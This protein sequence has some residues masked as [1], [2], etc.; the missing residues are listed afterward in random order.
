MI[1]MTVSDFE[2]FRGSIFNRAFAEGYSKGQEVGY[3]E[4]NRTLQRR[5]H[6][7]DAAVHTSA[8]EVY[9]SKQHDAPPGYS[10]NSHTGRYSYSLVVVT[11]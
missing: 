3:L 10:S 8:G 1:Q 7:Q 2:K 5:S 6:T 11:L 4:S 9:D